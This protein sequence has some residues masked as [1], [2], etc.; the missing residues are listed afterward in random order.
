M[1]KEL[2]KYEIR[3]SLAPFGVLIA[4]N[5]I[6]ALFLS[7]NK[8]N[9]ISPVIQFVNGI[10]GVLLALYTFKEFYDDFYEGKYELIHLIPVKLSTAVFVKIIVFFTG[11]L[12]L[13]ASGLFE[14]FF[15]DYG[16]YHKVIMKSPNP[17]TFIIFN[18]LGKIV[19][20]ISG[21]AL[22][23]FSLG[24]SKFLTGGK[25]WGIIA[26]SFTT[27]IVVALLIIMAA[28]TTLNAEKSNGVSFEVR[29][30]SPEGATVDYVQYAA[31]LPINSMSGTSRSSIT[32]NISWISIINNLILTIVLL[33]L[34]TLLFNSKR[35]EP[36][37]GR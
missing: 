10:A 23:A 28:N 3:K 15:S 19:S 27:S 36:C 18:I 22:L 30:Q 20:Y 32:V 4:F 25:W 11:F 33:P 37:D 7:I 24:F 5:I 8:D 29:I 9:Y 1:I 6:M 2:I 31:F 16:K 17:S 12:L 14:S 34:G 21:L 35:Y 26:L 13:Y